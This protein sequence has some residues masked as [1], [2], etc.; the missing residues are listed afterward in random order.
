[1]KAE[2]ILFITEDEICLC[3]FHILNDPYNALYCHFL[4]WPEGI[5]KQL[6]DKI[7]SHMHKLHKVTFIYY[8]L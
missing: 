3:H 6:Y 1:M 2:H 7:C 4:L 8:F 5:I